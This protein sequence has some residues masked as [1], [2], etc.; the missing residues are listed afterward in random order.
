MEMPDVRDPSQAPVG[1][2]H[3]WVGLRRMAN[4]AGQT[5][6]SPTLGIPIQRCPDLA[7]ATALAFQGAELEQLVVAELLSASVV[8]VILE[9]D[10]PVT[11]RFSFA[12]AHLVDAPRNTARV[13]LLLG[14]CFSL[15]GSGGSWSF[16]WPKLA[17][18]L[19]CA[20]HA[21]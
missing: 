7:A 3:W 21:C 15:H 14:C 9:L 2:T 12:V 8:D 19:S 17:V 11:S 16:N 10:A 13:V 4:K 5:Q 6:P 18:V 20:P 1:L